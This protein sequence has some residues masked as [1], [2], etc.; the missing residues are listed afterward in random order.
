MAVWIDGRVV[1]QIDGDRKREG[2]VYADAIN[3]YREIAVDMDH[4]GVSVYMPVCPKIP[5]TSGFQEQIEA[6]RWNEMQQMMEFVKLKQHL[7]TCKHYLSHLC[8][9][10]GSCF[11]RKHLQPKVSGFHGFHRPMTVF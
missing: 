11:L 2:T 10:N 4:S 9:M 3:A 7:N 5:K 8:V 1:T 6:L